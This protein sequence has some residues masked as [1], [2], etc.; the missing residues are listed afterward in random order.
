M[1]SQMQRMKHLLNLFY[2]D[3]LCIS[4]SISESGPSSILIPDISIPLFNIEATS[5]DGLLS[6]LVAALELAG[7]DCSKRFLLC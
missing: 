7:E 2:L 6:I 5:L 4:S 3:I 1:S